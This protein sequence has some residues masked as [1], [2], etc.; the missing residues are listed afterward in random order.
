MPF[1]PDMRDPGAPVPHRRVWA[2]VGTD[3][4]DVLF[5]ICCKRDPTKPCSVEIGQGLG[6]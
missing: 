3:S 4:R 2:S 5:A 1:P 6:A